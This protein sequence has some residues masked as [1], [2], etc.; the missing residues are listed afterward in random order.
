MFSILL[1]RKSHNITIINADSLAYYQKEKVIKFRWKLAG[2][3]HEGCLTKDL[4]GMSVNWSGCIIS[5][6]NERKWKQL[7]N[8]L[9]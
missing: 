8:F 3:A 1:K 6:N 4:C 9:L 5:E 2:R 7:S